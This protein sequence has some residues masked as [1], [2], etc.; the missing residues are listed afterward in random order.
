M[1]KVI[2]LYGPTAVGKSS[3]AIELAKLIN[4][5]IISADSMQVYQKLNVGTAKVTKEQMQGVPHHLLDILPPSQNYSVSD[6]CSDCNRLIEE[7]M[8]RGKTPIVVGG[9]GLYF[10]ALIEGYDFGQTARDDDFRASL[11]NLT[12]QELYKRICEYNPSITIDCNNRHRLVRALELL[13]FG[14]MPTKKENVFKYS[15]KLF[16]ISDDRKKVYER[17]NKRVDE[18]VNEGILDEVKFLLSLNLPDDNL[19]LKAI[20]Y[21]ELIP[22]VN[23]EAP[24]K[25]CLE[26][27]KQKTRNYAKRQFTFINQFKEKEVVNFCGVRETANI[28]SKKI[29]E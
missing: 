24:L 29:G 13:V 17:I 15:Y 16:V 28:I 26:L 4:G 14:K 11:E 6:F 9:T 5:E 21:K 25:D 3:I 8:A 22:Y 27:L 12:N 1:N 23:G 7:I 20:G 10:K 18:M 19:C 2:L